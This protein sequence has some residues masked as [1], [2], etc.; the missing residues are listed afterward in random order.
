M[1]FGGEL[2][3][4]F[5]CHVNAWKKLITLPSVTEVGHVKE[6]SARVDCW[7]YD[8]G[9]LTGEDKV[10]PLSLFLSLADFPDE[11]VRLASKSL[12]EDMQW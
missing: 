12:L 5:A 2:K 3:P 11:R 8:P 4:T 1:K 10:D 7:R 9:L 6:A